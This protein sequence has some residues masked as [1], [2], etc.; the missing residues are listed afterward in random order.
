MTDKP[1]KKPARSWSTKTLARQL[2]QYVKAHNI[3]KTQTVDEL[4]ASL[5]AEIV[6]QEVGTSLEL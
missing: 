5:K 1:Q 2:A 3:G 6:T 4:F